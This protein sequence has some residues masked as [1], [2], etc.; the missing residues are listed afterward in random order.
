M[1]LKRREYPLNKSQKNFDWKIYFLFFIKHKIS[2]GVLSLLESIYFLLFFRLW[3][4][5]NILY[6]DII[7][8]L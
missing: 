5:Y 3:Y 4:D 2:K 7:T 6:H 1:H 8:I